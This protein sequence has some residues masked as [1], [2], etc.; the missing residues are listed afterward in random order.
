MHDTGDYLI[1]GLAELFDVLR[2]TVYCVLQRTPGAEVSMDTRQLP[3]AAHHMH[4]RDADLSDIDR[5]SSPFSFSNKPGSWRSRTAYCPNILSEPGGSR[6]DLAGRFLLR[7][8]CHRALPGEPKQGEIV[9][10]G[11]LDRDLRAEGQCR[12][13]ASGGPVSRGAS[14]GQGRHLLYAF[15][16]RRSAPLGT[17]L[18]PRRFRSAPDLQG[19][20]AE[21]AAPPVQQDAPAGH[22]RSR[23]S[24]SG[25]DRPPWRG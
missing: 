7:D 10:C 12:A 5:L 9:G 16:S 13:R 11:Q 3:L 4:L 17:G 6:R 2:P 23:L 1:S 19:S 25:R 15:D 18:C 21:L 14:R 20:R 8:Q 24:G 22:D